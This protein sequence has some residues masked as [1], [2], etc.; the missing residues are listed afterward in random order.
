MTELVVPDGFEVELVEINDAKSMAVGYNEGMRRTDAKYKIYMHHD[1]FIT[2]KNF[3][4]DLLNIFQENADIGMI[5][6][7][8][9]PYLVKDGVMWH[10]IRYGSFYRLQ[11]YLK[12]NMVERFFSFETGYLEVEAVDGLL[13]ATQY[14]IPW[15]EDI[16]SK[17][18]FYDVS[19]SFEFIKAGYKVVVPG[20][21]PEWFI[22]DSIP[23]YDNYNDER[24]KFLENYPEYMSARKEE[25]GKQYLEHT[26]ERVE[27][28]FR[29]TE[30]EREHLLKQLKELTEEKE[31]HKD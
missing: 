24:D 23:K 8:G 30:E 13:M 4:I 17:W 7:V 16:F 10:G 21:M 1:V 25:T 9:T 3:L 14:D 6:M 29:G 12:K 22:H 2:N 26:I 31:E 18:D 11:S 28:G 5:G 20:Q 19:Q 27:K 15:R